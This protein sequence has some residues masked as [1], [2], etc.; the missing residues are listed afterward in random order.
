MDAAESAWRQLE[1]FAAQ[2]DADKLAHRIGIVEGFLDARIG[3]AELVLQQVDAQHPLQDYRG[4]AIPGFRIDR[5]DQRAKLRPW[6]HA[7][8]VGQKS[9]L[10]SAARSQAAAPRALARNALCSRAACSGT[11]S[12]PCRFSRAIWPSAV[13]Q[14]GCSLSAGI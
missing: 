9:R 10:L 4:L 6:R 3:Q 1:V 11:S 13:I 14:A 8:H 12:Q 2:V 5:L 7:L